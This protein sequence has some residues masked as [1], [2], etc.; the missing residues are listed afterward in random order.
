MTGWNLVLRIV[1]GVVIALAI[2]GLVFLFLPRAN[3]VRELQGRKADLETDNRATEQ[4]IKDLKSQQEKFNSDP[5]FVERTARETGLI[6][7]DE[8][9]FRMTNSVVK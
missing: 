2:V 8:T 1:T 6:K 7:P 9:V 5:A 4:R 3:Q